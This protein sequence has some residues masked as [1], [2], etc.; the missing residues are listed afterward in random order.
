MTDGS[1]NNINSNNHSHKHLRSTFNL[2]KQSIKHTKVY[3]LL[4]FLS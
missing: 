1:D 4:Y 3:T 2:L